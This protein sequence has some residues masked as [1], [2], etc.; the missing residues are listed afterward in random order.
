MDL[1]IIELKNVSRNY[2]MGE[3]EVQALK[4]ID[5][6]VKQG[7]FMAV[8]GH[9]G[10][11]KT[12]IMNI[13]GLIDDPSSGDVFIGGDRV[14]GLNDIE[15]TRMRRESLGFIFQSFNL[16]P[17]LSVE[18]NIELPLMLGLRPPVKEERQDRVRELVKSVGLEK[19][20]NH[21]PGELSGGQRQRVAIARALIGRPKIVVADEPTANLDTGTSDEILKLM[22]D[23]NEVYRTT[24]VFSSHDPI[25]QDMAAHVVHLKD[26]LIEREERFS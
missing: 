2:P 20:R 3:V 5:L 25:I 17:V 16:L 19:W 9:S 7:D 22:R 14:G 23:I 11:G 26:G 1:N 6:S 10:A 21:K 12:T 4:G 13:I 24:F 15:K 8:V 18:E